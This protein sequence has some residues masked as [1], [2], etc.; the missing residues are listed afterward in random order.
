MRMGSTAQKK[1]AELATCK[2]L[3]IPRHPSK[4][5]SL[6]SRICGED[7]PLH[8]EGKG[9]PVHGCN[10][11]AVHFGTPTRSSSS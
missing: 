11:C 8:D 2:A 7:W 9:K 10:A 5:S 3:G 1:V 4:A 6:K